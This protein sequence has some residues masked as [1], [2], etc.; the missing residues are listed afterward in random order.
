MSLDL[1]TFKPGLLEALALDQRK[2]IHLVMIATKPDIIK[3]APLYLELKQRNE[4]VLLGHTGQHYEFN[5]SGGMIEE[6]GISP[7][8]NL[9]I[10]GPLHQKI[11]Q[12]IGRLGDLLVE[13]KAL[14]K[15]VIPYV[16]GDTMTA[17][18]VSNAAH[19]LE[20]ASV[21][22]ES[23]IRTL[24]PKREIF[25]KLLENFDWNWYYTALQDRSNWE[26]GSIEP[27]PEQYN[28]RAVGPGTGLFCAPVT[29]DQEFL[30]NEGY[31]ADRIKVVGNTVTDALQIALSNQSKSTIFEKYPPLKDGFIRF[32]V[33]RREN[34]SNSQRFTSIFSAIEE[35][36]N[37]NETVLLISMYQ[38]KVAI[39]E[40]GL[41]SRL[42]ALINKPNFIYSE[43]W[44]YYTDVIAAME[45]ATV[46]ATDSG[47]MQEE[48]NIMGIPC[49]TLRYGSDRS[50]T[51]LDGGN[52][53]APPINGP[54][55][56][57]IIRAA[58]SEPRMKNRPKLYGENVSIKI[59]DHVLELLE[60]EPLFRFEHHR[61]Q[62]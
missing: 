7:D 51:I 34:C 54:L 13:L 5:L 29:L 6:F 18:A 14:G 47:S 10:E 60:K 38:T 26:S 21:H 42:N 41:Q 39:E 33:H 36:V 61:L 58:Q 35:L 45:K 11:S 16:H 32:C 30:L 50:E 3:Q 15:I 44:P 19:G 48:M 56:A 24:T 62:L 2:H 25:V 40:F 22:V 37:A 57:K 43:S 49:V 9:N 28:T 27:Y 31:P 12:T 53:I 4:L 46:C 59:V 55:I 1:I 17:M 23:G 8:F 52:V 20:F